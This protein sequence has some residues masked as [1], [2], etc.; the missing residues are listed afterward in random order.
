MF[1]DALSAEDRAAITASGTRRTFPAG[2]TV[3]LYGDKPTHALIVLGGLAK[4]ARSSSDGRQMMIELRGP[5]DILGE[6]GVLDDRPRSADI[7]VIEDLEAI[8][9]PTPALRQLVLERGTIAYAVLVAV[10]DR[11]RQATERQLEAGASDATSRLC[12][13]LLE[14]S[15]YG[16]ADD[17]GVI[18]LRSPLT[19]EELANWIGVSRDAVVL[20]MR[21]IRN[22]GWVETGRRT[23]RI[24][25][26]D[27][28][29]TAAT[30]HR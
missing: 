21:K 16:T 14:L 18:E 20:A 1:W 17:H 29:A 19:Q 26:I 11:L 6:L 15:T 30:S 27:A 12:G 4:L 13:R 7:V 28:I 22:A 5:G 23:I 24:L 3:W 8:V 25:D 2:T 10:A 9:V